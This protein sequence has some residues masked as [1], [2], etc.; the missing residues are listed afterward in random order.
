M[1]IVAHL[2]VLSTILDAEAPV[3]TETEPHFLQPPLFWADIL[4]KSL[5]T[6]RGNCVHW[7]L[8][9]EYHKE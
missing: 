8:G 5:S 9:G 6:S 2:P 1:D 4:A 7:G 3:W